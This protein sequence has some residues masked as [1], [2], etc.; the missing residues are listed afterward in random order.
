MIATL[1]D[2]T[3]GAEHLPV[4]MRS[5]PRVV[6]L[7]AFVSRAV[8]LMGRR[9]LRPDIAVWLTPCHSVHTFGVRFPL[10]IICLDAK[11]NILRLTQRVGPC[12]IVCVPGTRS[13]IES[14]SIEGESFSRFASRARR[15]VCS[16][17]SGAI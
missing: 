1:P 2:K 9:A 16:L 13:V 4:R 14:A 7:D 17:E 12:R 11:R 3:S 6:R 8:G 5:R 10:D 15:V